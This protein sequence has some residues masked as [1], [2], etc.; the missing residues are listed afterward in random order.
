MAG[1]LH[2]GQAA[3]CG[4]ATTAAGAGGGDRNCG[5]GVAA[6]AK[7]AM[8]NGSCSTAAGA[9]AALGATV[10]TVTTAPHLHLAFFPASSGFHRNSRPHDAQENFGASAVAMKRPSYRSEAGMLTGAAKTCT[11]RRRER[12]GG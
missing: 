8:S 1:A 2:T 3:C 7:S 9:G 11:A 6:S 10:G 5:G 4:A 12:R